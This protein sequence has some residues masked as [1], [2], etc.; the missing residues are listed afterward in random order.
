MIVWLLFVAFVAVND[1]VVVG[2]RSA[3]EVNFHPT[4]V[5]TDMF[6][7]ISIMLIFLFFIAIRC[8]GIKITAEYLRQYQSMKI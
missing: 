7:F 6:D 4:Q 8:I 5:M 3:H 1:G 2:D